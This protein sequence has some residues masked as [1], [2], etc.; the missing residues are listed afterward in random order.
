[1]SNTKRLGIYLGTQTDTPENI[2]E[3][4]KT[5]GKYLSEYELETFGSPAL[6]ESVESQ[7][8]HT[9][10][11]Q[12]SCRTPFHKILAAYRHSIE[13]IAKRSPDALIQIWTYTTHGPGVVAAGKKNGVPTV[14]RITGDVFNEYGGKTGLAQWGL[15]LLS[16]GFGRLPLHLADRIITLGPRS[17][18]IA[19]QYGADQKRLVVLPPPKPEADQFH[20]AQNKS[21]HRSHHN[22]FSDRP[23]ALYVGRLSKQKGIPFLIEVMESVLQNTDFVFVLIGEGKYSDKIARRFSDEDVILAGHVDHQSIDAYY[24]ASD[25]YVHAS[26]YE[27]IPLVILEALSC[28]LPIV[29]RNAGD[30]D[31]V[32]S[33]IVDT[34]EEMARL[35]CDQAWDTEWQNRTYFEP[36]YQQETLENVVESLLSD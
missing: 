26:P 14:A 9:R 4:L 11:D 1:M 19:T 32:T 25:L 24:K 30:I 20:P 22:L 13:Y 15:F 23:T 6:P 27:G 2:E 16:H 33:N 3:V 8:H 31:F 7:Y 36:E 35:I 21:A 12:H 28:D 18:Q 17:A 5:W 29:A 10:L 34:S